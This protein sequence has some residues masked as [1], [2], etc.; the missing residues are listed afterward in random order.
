MSDDGY[1]IYR[2]RANGDVAEKKFRGQSFRVDNRHVVPYNRQLLLLF[3]C[4]INVEVCSTI[5]S[6][7][8][9]FKYI[10]KG[11][12]RAAI[13]LQTVD[14][15]VVAPRNE[16]DVSR[17]NNRMT[18]TQMD[19]Q[20]DCDKFLWTKNQ[21]VIFRSIWTAD[22]SRHPRLAGASSAL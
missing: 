12:D 4:H 6:I 22:T 14:G 18:N 5:K 3:D 17:D 10:T 11:P 9:V 1:P 13:N 2:R 20:T 8:Y 21:L 15:T 7:K 19:R 16:I